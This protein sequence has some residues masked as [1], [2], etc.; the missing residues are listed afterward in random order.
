MLIPISMLW[1]VRM[2]WRRKAA[3]I[4][5]FSLVIIVMIIAI[6]RVAVVI[7]SEDSMKSVSW[8]T[9]WSVVECFVGK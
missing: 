2:E 5:L 4:S 8:V 9:M 3:L 7:S 1:G 6:I